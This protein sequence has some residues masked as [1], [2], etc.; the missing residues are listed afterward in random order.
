M[1]LALAG[2]AL[3]LPLLGGCAAAAGMAAVGA[4]GSAG[5]YALDCPSYV[6]VTVRD[7][8]T[9]GERCGERVV[10]VNGERRR[11]LT[12]CSYAP[13]PEGSWVLHASRTDLRVPESRIEIEPEA[14]CEHAV[15]SVELA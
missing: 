8:L 7:P 14:H 5:A 15:Y 6:M 13:L 9:G 3:L 10:A 11:E 2:L 4:V 1:R 12:S